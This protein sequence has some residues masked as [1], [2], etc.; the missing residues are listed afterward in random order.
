MIDKKILESMA[1]DIQNLRRVA[2]H[3]RETGKGIESIERNI[4]RILSSVRL[5]ELN[6]ADVVRVI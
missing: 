4:I 3:L 5:L 2:E 1:D 6:V